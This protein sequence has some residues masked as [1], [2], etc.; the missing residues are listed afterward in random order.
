M[1][2][3]IISKKENPLLSR[4]EIVFEVYHGGEATPSR[5][6]VRESL[7]KMIKAKKE[8]LVI[9]HMSPNFGRAQTAGYAKLYS[10]K[11]MALKME[12]RAILIRNGLI[13]KPKEE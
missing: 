9:D 2:V 13:E 7:S 11:E 12:R 4:T 1:E 5:D 6:Q 10:S 8:T 3:K